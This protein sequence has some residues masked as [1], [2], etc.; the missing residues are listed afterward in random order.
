[1][2]NL[3]FLSPFPSYPILT[4]IVLKLLLISGAELGR[5]LW[6][7]WGA[8]S[9]ERGAGLKEGGHT[10]GR[11]WSRSREKCFLEWKVL[12]MGEPGTAK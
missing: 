1:M 12:G 9:L 7:G 3:P 11:D 6:R 8:G 4:N 5:G 10:E 2:V